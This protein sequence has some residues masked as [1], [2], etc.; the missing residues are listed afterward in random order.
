MLLNICIL[1]I[2]FY[3]SEI[4]HQ[5]LNRD[6]YLSYYVFSC[7]FISLIIFIQFLEEKVKN[8]F[9]IILNSCLIGIV[10]F[11]TLLEFKLDHI[12]TKNKINYD[13]N[14]YKYILNDQSRKGY[15]PRILPGAL[16]PNGLNNSIYPASS[17]SFK[18]TVMCKEG[19]G[20]ITYFSD[21]FGFNNVDSIWDKQNSAV[22]IGDSFV[23]GDCVD[24]N[25]T[26]SSNL[27]K[28]NNPKKFLNLGMGGNGPLLKLLSLREFGF[29]NKTKNVLWFYFEGND[30]IEMEFEKS[31][32][33]LNLYLNDINF[34]QNL[35]LKTSFLDKEFLK[36]HSRNIKK[37][38]FPYTFI[39]HLKHILLFKNVRGLFKTLNIRKKNNH[40]FD[41]VKY[42]KI[43]KSAQDLAKLNNA[44]FYFI[45]L[46]AFE[47]FSKVNEDHESFLNKNIVIKKMKDDG[48]NVIDISNIV[49]E[50]NKDPLQY[51]PNRQQGHYNEKGYMAIAQQL[52][53]VILFK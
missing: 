17:I 22:L 40:D 50:K 20:M 21:R 41:I 43:L 15:V 1:T 44:N 35:Y 48:I 47:R 27:N 45:Y 29:L 10:I 16:L 52:S 34:T 19:S 26:I 37:Q 7:I 25:N 3:K 53:K 11:E 36:I 32:K 24:Q 46:P 4:L 14:P 12:L 51:F 8:N 9:Y 33:I 38:K 6:H 2:T 28:I 30:F 42:S 18:N 23:H 5:G 13:Y 31:S 39:R 49:F